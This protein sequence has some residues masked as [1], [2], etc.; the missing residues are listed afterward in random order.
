M[1]DTGRP[2]SG[3]NIYKH[4]RL[5]TRKEMDEDR[6]NEMKDITGGKI[7]QLTDK[8]LNGALRDSIKVVASPA[9][10][11]KQI[12]QL[13][14]ENERLRDALNDAYKYIHKQGTLGD[15]TCKQCRP[16]SGILVDG[17]VCQFHKA[18]AA[19]QDNTAGG[20]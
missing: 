20:K 14:T 13:Q 2:D 17:F 7:E 12:S 3:K 9:E 6:M 15:W 11:L 8:A 16:S 5:K 19:L 4:G 18:E 1:S 10:L